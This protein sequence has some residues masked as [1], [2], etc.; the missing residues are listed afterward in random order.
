M[1]L[2]ASNTRTRQHGA[3]LIAVML[4]LIV[5]SALGIGAVQI[6]MMGERS[7]RNDRDMQVAWQA[8]EA[9]LMDAQF[10]IQGDGTATGG[11]R[12]AIFGQAPKDPPVVDAF[13]VGCDGTGNE[14]GL[15]NAM[16]IPVGNRPPWLTIDFTGANARTVEFGDF[17]SR[18][19]P[20]NGGVRSAQ[21]P[22]YLIELLRDH[23]AGL[24]AGD[25][26]TQPQYFMYRVTSMGFGPREEI[27]AV[28]QMLMRP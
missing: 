9:A 15:C 8:A 7:A 16:D 12:S 10:D 27:R 3:S 21:P 25:K 28:A 17:T 4:I 20:S 22:R 14:V 18:D 24:K 11:D 5:V 1:R 2:P 19:Y 6:S 23:G 26:G 13:K